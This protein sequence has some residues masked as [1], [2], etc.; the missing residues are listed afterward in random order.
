[1]VYILVGIAAVLII[2]GFILNGSQKW[3]VVSSN[4]I[5]SNV[6]SVNKQVNITSNETCE[7]AEQ[8]VTTLASLA[9]ENKEVFCP[10]KGS[11]GEYGVWF[12]YNIDENALYA[13]FPSTNMSQDVFIFTYY[14]SI[15][16]DVDVIGAMLYGNPYNLSDPTC[17]WQTI[18]PANNLIHDWQSFYHLINS[19]DVSLLSTYAQNILCNNDSSCNISFAPCYIEPLNTTHFMAG[20][21]R[22]I[23]E[24]LASINSTLS[25]ATLSSLKDNEVYFCESTPFTDPSALGENISSVKIWIKYLNGI[26]FIYSEETINKSTYT[27]LDSSLFGINGTD[28]LVFSPYRS[29]HVEPIN[30]SEPTISFNNE[31][32]QKC[33]WLFMYKTPSQLTFN[34]SQLAQSLPGYT[35]ALYYLGLIPLDSLSQ[36]SME[37]Y[38]AA[39]MV[40]SCKVVN[41]SVH[42]HIFKHY[43]DTTKD[44]FWEEY[45]GVSKNLSN[46]STLN[47]S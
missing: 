7:E 42:L 27:T 20:C 25:N 41:D 44:E 19:T 23:E 39:K 38:D 12:A 33:P 22:S 34:S 30:S 18:Y 32:S 35:L 47:T 15:E 24:A 45:F 10:I 13:A 4:N 11:N 28:W 2:G 17:G 26:I 1:M 31:L 40:L 36:P 43:C 46:L 8:Q 37:Q 9:K 5:S 29:V 3:N 6:S 16:P 21:Q 14:P